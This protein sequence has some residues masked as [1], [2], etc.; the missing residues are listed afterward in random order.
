MTHKK[1]LYQNRDPDTGE[2]GDKMNERQRFLEDARA[3]FDT[4]DVKKAA[5]IRRR[6]D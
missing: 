1:P 4:D 6:K 5:G 2:F 3:A